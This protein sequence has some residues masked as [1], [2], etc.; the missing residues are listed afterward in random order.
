MV[1]RGTGITWYDAAGGSKRASTWVEDL[2]S[3]KRLVANSRRPWQDRHEDGQATHLRYTSNA[4]NSNSPDIHK[5]G[6]T[7]FD[8]ADHY[9]TEYLFQKI[10]LEGPAEDLM[11]Y[12]ALQLP[13]DQLQCFT[14]WCPSPGII[15]NQLPILDRLLA[16]CNCTRPNDTRSSGRGD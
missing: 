8:G 9:G 15:Y 6:F 11:G 3:D 1:S 5:A 10:T 2:S 14:K 7:T 13:E 4:Q 16:F 12:L